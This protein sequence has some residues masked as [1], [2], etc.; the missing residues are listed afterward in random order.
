M[1]DIGK[2]F[3]APSKP[4]MLTNGSAAPGAASAH[5][6]SLS[7]FG[8]QQLQDQQQHQVGG[9]QVVGKS[10]FGGNMTKMTSG[11]KSKVKVVNGPSP[12]SF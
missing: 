4:L 6:R 9:L 7:K 3:D 8:Q 2:S 12:A 10:I 11:Y 1:G 5:A